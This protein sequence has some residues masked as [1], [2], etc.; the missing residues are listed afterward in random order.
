MKTTIILL[1]V[2]LLSFS[3]ITYKDVMSI[4]SLNQFKRIMIEK[5]YEY[6]ESLENN[7]MILYGYNITRDSIKGDKATSWSYYNIK[8]NN[9]TI[10]LSVKSVFGV[11]LNSTDNYK[12]PYYLITE[13]IKKKCRFYKII[14]D[15]KDDIDF[16][17]YSCSESTYKGKIGFAIYDGQGIIKHFTTY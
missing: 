8:N 1:F 2:P 15:K 10:E 5:N 14:K 12:N 16:A 17:T 9:W 4:N 6:D 13:N 3:Q 11:F 7:N